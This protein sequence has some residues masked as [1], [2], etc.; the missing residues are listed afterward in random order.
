M[1]ARRALCVFDLKRGGVWRLCWAAVS[2]LALFACSGPTA[3][4][5]AKPDSANAAD[6]HGVAD[7]DAAGLDTTAP[8]TAE[9]DTA[10]A[11]TAATDIA[12]PDPDGEG[13][14]DAPD[15]SDAQADGSVADQTS[16]SDAATT[17][18][19]TSDVAGDCAGQDGCQQGA[20]SQCAPCNTDKD[21]ASAQAGA[22]SCV[23][24]GANGGFCA[25][26]CKSASDCPAPLVCTATGSVAG[27]VCLPAEGIQAC[28]CS[29]WAVSTA[30]STTCTAAVGK[31]LCPGTRSCTSVG[32]PSACIPDPQQPCIDAVCQGSKNGSLCDDSNACTANTTC[33]N[34]LCTGGKNICEC[35]TSADCTAKN[36]ANLCNGS[37]YCD[38][39]TNS[40]VLDP[41]SIVDCTKAMV[42]SCEVA[43]C[44]PLSGQCVPKPAKQGIACDDGDPCTQNVCQNGSC[45]AT[46][47]VCACQTAADCQDD[48]NLCNGTPYCDKS[49][50]PYSCKTNP[51]SIVTC[52]TPS[53]PCLVSSCNKA[54]GQCATLPGPDGLPCNDGKPCTSGDACEGGV[55]SSGVITCA[56]TTHADCLAQDDGNLCNGTAFCNF[57][58]GKCQLNPASVVSCPSGG[59]TQC[60][61]NRCQPKTGQCAMTPRLDGL[62]C[63]DGNPCSANESCQAGLC[64][65][66]ADI[67]PCK[68]AADCPDD[69]NACN[70]LLYC[71]LNSNTC[72]VNPASVVVCLPGDNACAPVQCDPA[73]GDC[74]PSPVVDGVACDDGEPCTALGSCVAGTCKNGAD[75][76]ECEVDADCNLFENGNL[77][78]GTLY[79]DKTK[80]ACVVSPTTVVSCSTANDTACSVARCA[81]K[82]GQCALT[83]VAM[84]VQCQDGNPCTVNDYC[85][86]GACNTGVLVCLCQTDADCAKYDDGDLCNGL[87]Y[88]DQAGLEPN[89]APQANSAVS[90]DQ[91]KAPT[92]TSMVCAP[93]TGSCGPQ[94]IAGNCDDGNTCT[95]NDFCLDAACQPG[96]VQVCNDANPCTFDLCVSGQGCTHTLMPNAPCNDA[97][98][99]TKNDRCTAAGAC[100]GAPTICEDGKDCTEDACQQSVGCIA[101][102]APGPCD[103]DN[104]CTEQDTCAA[105]ECVGTAKDCDDNNICTLDSC[106]GG[107]TYAPSPAGGLCD[108]GDACTTDD[109]CVDGSCGGQQVVCED[110]GE[111]CT[112]QVCDALLGCTL[113]Q[114]TTGCDDG[115]LCTQD[116][117]C[118]NGACVGVQRDCDP[119]GPTLGAC[120]SMTGCVAPAQADVCDGLDNDG[121]GFTDFPACGQPC[122]CFAGAHLICS[123]LCTSCPDPVDLAVTYLSSDSASVVCAHQFPAW[124]LR[125]PTGQSLVVANGVATDPLTGLAWTEQTSGAL[126]G[127]AAA[128]DWCDQLQTGGF[129]DWRLP[130]LHE[131]LSVYRAGLAAESQLLPG[132][133]DPLGAPHMSATPWGA[134]QIRMVVNYATGDIQLGNAVT[135]RVARCVRAGGNVPAQRV[136]SFGRFVVA[137]NVVRDNATGLDWTEPLPL[138]LAPQT[139]LDW[140]AAQNAC[141][142]L[143]VDGGAAWR[144][145]TVAE[146]MSLWMPPTGSAYVLDPVA[147]PSGQSSALGWFWT[148][149]SADASAQQHWQVSAQVHDVQAANN[150]AQVAVRCVR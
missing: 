119:N 130:T 18:V 121:D 62:L 96:P 17:D 8:D 110:T 117:T 131:L 97:E 136:S 6:A 72:K 64:L 148:A 101:T 61:A 37:L 140:N 120:S 63:D 29:A 53:D 90:C 106:N 52:A 94:P 76:C 122:F 133:A 93:K 147:F 33:Q 112:A 68:K 57:A 67:C 111:Q 146:L 47:N 100:Q 51:A 58:T 9:A 82:T 42:G 49:Q 23:L 127:Y 30:A 22:A 39:T 144:L 134:T 27:A 128:R 126:A 109:E 31:Q 113:V 99:C 139:G 24:A 69:G 145:P 83:N 116:D 54:T 20:V 135:T 34:G 108:D 98:V 71:D 3:P 45:V 55:C 25:T 92:C 137:T 28:A 40:C 70:G 77:C 11:G 19:A 41:A 15:S 141:A 65:A 102:P 89:C 86:Q 44:E 4:V 38:L 84:G 56:C 2:C 79:C 50:F 59:D 43:V 81:P 95:T 78:D 104:S 13:Q 10:E 115:Q 75:I 46:A 60:A 32:A 138:A 150:D 132:L 142:G 129:V 91:A 103:D 35:Q 85:A 87:W 114:L 107:C 16:A 143:D 88:C 12:Q 73:S 36:D 21:C 66:T 5:D 149:S 26:S 124:G 123:T 48:G 14:A 125:Q 105:G 1:P 118:S 7:T 74:Q 80:N